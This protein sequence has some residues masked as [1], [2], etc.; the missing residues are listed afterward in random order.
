MC[1]SGTCSLISADAF[2][3]DL[4]HAKRE[5][6]RSAPEKP[7]PGYGFTESDCS[8]G[9]GRG[10]NDKTSTR[11]VLG[12]MFLKLTPPLAGTPTPLRKRVL[13]LSVAFC[14]FS[15]PSFLLFSPCFLARGPLKSRTTSFGVC[16]TRIHVTLEQL[17]LPFL[18]AT[19]CHPHRLL[20]SSSLRVRSRNSP[21]MDRLTR[22]VLSSGFRF[23][24][25]VRI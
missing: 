1:H 18:L 21:S 16:L 7:L 12:G 22:T 8:R 9:Q 13:N 23:E 4:R 10:G 25:A 6:L 24:S 15:S 19:S 5:H 11:G 2:R 14:S 17:A 20:L 3:W